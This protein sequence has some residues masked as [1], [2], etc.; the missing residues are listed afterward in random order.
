MDIDLTLE[1]ALATLEAWKSEGVIDTNGIDDSEFM[2][3]WNAMTDR[4]NKRPVVYK[5]FN[6]SYNGGRKAVKARTAEE[7]LQRYAAYNQQLSIYPGTTVNEIT[8][9]EAEGYY[10]K[11]D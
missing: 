4:Q 7:A 6:V 11:I 3:A 5:W 8:A 9:E 1:G 2:K 10:Y